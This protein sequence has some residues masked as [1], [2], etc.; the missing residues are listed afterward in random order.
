MGSGASKL[1]RAWQE[2]ARMLDRD[3]FIINETM[4]GTVPFIIAKRNSV[5]IRVALLIETHMN[6]EV[7]L[8]EAYSTV[9][10]D[11]WEDMVSLKSDSEDDDSDSDEAAG[12]SGTRTAS[13]TAVADQSDRPP[14]LERGIQVATSQDDADDD[15][16]APVARTRPV[17]SR[18]AR[19]SDR[20]RKRGP[21]SSATSQDLGAGTWETDAESSTGGREQEDAVRETFQ[22]APPAR[23]ST[24]D[25]SDFMD[26]MPT[27]NLD[28]A[29]AADG[30]DDDGADE[31]CIVHKVEVW[32]AFRS[33]MTM[34]EMD[35]SLLRAIHDGSLSVAIPERDYR[36]R[37]AIVR[38]RVNV[39]YHQYGTLAWAYNTAVDTYLAR[40]AAYLEDPERQQDPQTRE[41]RGLLSAISN[42][43]HRLLP[44]HNADSESVPQ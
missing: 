39:W 33:Y 41:L 28:G 22:P 11:G 21:A 44:M 35:R 42:Y 36:Q 13:V 1:P 43:R 12:H 7:R 8:V 18:H 6:M 17:A 19:P 40:S 14:D 4:P 10:S 5:F 20:V 2:N 27:G 31:W 25:I 34:K 9:Q 3:T 32:N 23:V 15:D 16:D 30:G 37:D 24:V 26:S 29:N 38:D